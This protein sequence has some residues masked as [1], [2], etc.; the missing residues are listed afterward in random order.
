MQKKLKINKE[1]IK[2]LNG[3]YILLVNNDDF[4]ETIVSDGKIDPFFIEKRISKVVVTK[5][6]NR[7]DGYILSGFFYPHSGFLDKD[8]LVSEIN[9]CHEKRHYRLLTPEEVCVA[10][11]SFMSNWE[12]KY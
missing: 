2:H 11:K 4:S 1:D 9:D 10:Y 5:D 12:S 8:G 7:K 3:R 6:T